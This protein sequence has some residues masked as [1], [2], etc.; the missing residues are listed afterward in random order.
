MLWL[1]FLGGMLGTT[2]LTVPNGAGTSPVGK[3]GYYVF[4]EKQYCGFSFTVT[5]KQFF[6]LTVLKKWFWKNKG[7]NFLNCLVIV[8]C[9]KFLSG[10]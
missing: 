7:C 9:H 1:I 4:V 8:K 2:D 6:I 10:I 5:Q 3:C